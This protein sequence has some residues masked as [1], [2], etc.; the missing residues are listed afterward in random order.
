MTHTRERTATFAVGAAIAALVAA[1]AMVLGGGPAAAL[2]Q[3]SEPQKPRGDLNVKV[4]ADRFFVRE[5][6]VFAAGTSAASFRG[7][8][9]SAADTGGPIELQVDSTNNCRVLELHLAE[10]YLDLLG[11]QVR[12]STIN[13]KVT[14]DRKQA[15]GR[16]F[17]KLSDALK[18]SKSAE[19]KRAARSL[20]RRLGDRGL[21]V[22]EFTATVHQ[23]QQGSAAAR[24]NRQGQ[25]PP[26]PADACRV[27]DLLL[28]PLDLDLLGLVVELYGATEGDPIRVN[29]VADRNGGQLG[30]SFCQLSGQ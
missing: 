25:A 13:L 16:L 29:I 1:L 14:G 2:A 18:L 8:D 7:N 28:G 30:A 17:C 12:T 4:K 15:L 19:A 11:L 20:N 24:G 21:P 6:A 22:L 3:E 26:P 5:G 10:L 23:Q 27:L 9:G